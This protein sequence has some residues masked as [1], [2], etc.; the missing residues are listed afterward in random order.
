MIIDSLS[1]TY[2]YTSLHPLFYKAL[3]YAVDNYD[4]LEEGCYELNG[5]RLKATVEVSEMR[6]REEAVLEAHD[7]YIDIQLPL[8]GDESYGWR[9]RASC[10]DSRGYDRERDV[11][12][13]DDAPQ[14]YFTVEPGQFAVFF[15]SDAH[16]PLV[17][18][19]GKIKK[20]VIKIRVK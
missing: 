3:N 19:A 2:R 13:F 9:H 1:E 15:P 4:T 10:C 17:G 14:D 7:R 8:S 12:F 6:S 5:D 20:C 11:E 16:A 18:R